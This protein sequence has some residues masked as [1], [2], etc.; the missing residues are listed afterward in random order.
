MIDLM[1]MLEWA[2]ARPALPI[3]AQKPEQSFFGTC[4]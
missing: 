2:M 1:A 3:R 4:Q